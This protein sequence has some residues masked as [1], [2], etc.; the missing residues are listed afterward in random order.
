MFLRVFL[1]FLCVF[2]VFFWFWGRGDRGRVWEVGGGLVIGGSFFL[3]RVNKYGRG[4]VWKVFLKKLCLMLWCF[5]K[6]WI[7]DVVELCRCCCLLLN[8]ML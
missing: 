7:V 6:V 1:V 3:E 5:V 8:L 2:F 4:L